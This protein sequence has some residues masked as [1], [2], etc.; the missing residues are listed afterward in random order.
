[1]ARNKLTISGIWLVPFLSGHSPLQ[2]ECSFH[3]E[4]NT[5]SHI[6][7]IS[8]NHGWQLGTRCNYLPLGLLWICEEFPICFAPDMGKEVVTTNRYCLLCWERTFLRL[9]KETF[10]RGQIE[11]C[12]WISSTAATALGQREWGRLGVG[13]GNPTF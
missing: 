6:A 2:S 10:T 12:L 11:V 1:M 7:T 9:A 4:G 8:L 3:W 5:C 13:M